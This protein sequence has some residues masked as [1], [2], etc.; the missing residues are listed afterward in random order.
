MRERRSR[1][2]TSTSS[3][4]FTVVEVLVALL[5][6]VVELSVGAVSLSGGPLL[7][8]PS[9]W[10]SIGGVQVLGWQDF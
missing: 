1:P 6:A 2:T 10:L 5:I 7:G 8:P 3:R 4:G 9:S